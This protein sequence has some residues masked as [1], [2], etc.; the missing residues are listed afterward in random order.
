MQT[1]LDGVYAA[2]IRHLT[3][4]V[5]DTWMPSLTTDT[6][7]GTV[8]VCGVQLKEYLERG[9]SVERGFATLIAA[10]IYAAGETTDAPEPSGAAVIAALHRGGDSRRQ[11]AL[12]LACHQLVAD[13]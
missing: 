4:H 8:V 6:S 2:V 1:R 5:D 7:D 12:L 9:S 3:V 13:E 11:A 10:V